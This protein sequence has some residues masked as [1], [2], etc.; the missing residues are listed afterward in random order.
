VWFGFFNAAV[1]H[2]LLHGFYKAY[3]FLSAGNRAFETAKPTPI[4]IKPVQGSTFL[5]DSRCFSICLFDRKGTELN[6]SIFLTLI[7]AITVGQATNIVKEQSL[8]LFQNHF[9]T[10]FVVCG[11]VTYTAIYK[12][13]T[14]LM[15]DMPMVL[16]HYRYLQLK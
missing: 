7:V 16:C 12:G 5:W 6:S 15:S 8:S 10:I 9:A 13:V 2:L 3:L 14:I 4:K 11:M 1:V